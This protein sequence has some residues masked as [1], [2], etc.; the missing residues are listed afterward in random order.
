MMFQTY[1]R[2]SISKKNIKI[3]TCGNYESRVTSNENTIRNH[4][5]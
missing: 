3:E 5:D 1:T 2:E 4:L